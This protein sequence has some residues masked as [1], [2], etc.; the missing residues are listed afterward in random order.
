[1]IMNE[2]IRLVTEE[3]VKCTSRLRSEQSNP[4]CEADASDD[5]MSDLKNKIKEL[6]RIR[7]ELEEL[8]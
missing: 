4:G 3:I 8:L 1:M 5:L 7:L 6:R 2:I